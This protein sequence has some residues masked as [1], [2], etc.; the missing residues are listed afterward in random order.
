MGSTE[1]S[2]TRYERIPM[3][4]SAPRNQ[5]RACEADVARH[6][7]RGNRRELPSEVDDAAHG[8]D[9]SAWRN[10]GRR[11]PQYGRV[12]GESSERERNP[13]QRCAYV[14]RRRRTEDPPVRTPC[15]RPAP[16]NAPGLGGGCVRPSSP[17][18]NPRRRG[19]PPLLPATARRYRGMSVADDRCAANSRD[20]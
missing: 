12:R 11:R 7:G 5:K 3:H 16:P 19:P 13:E 6:N 1:R 8:S 17:P 9:A 2:S 10:E 18:P 14:M 15:R 4:C 20:R